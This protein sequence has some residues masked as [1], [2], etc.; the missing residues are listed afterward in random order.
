[1]ADT[2]KYLYDLVSCDTGSYPT[3]TKLATAVNPSPYDGLV[4]SI[5][6]QPQAEIYTVTPL[7]L[8]AALMSA[9]MPDLLVANL[10]SCADTDKD[11]IYRVV[12]CENLKDIRFVKLAAAQTIGD[13]LR[14]DGECTCWRVTELISTYDEIPVIASTFTDCSSCREV[15]V[16]ENCLFEERTYGY[17]VMVRVPKDEPVDRGYNECCVVGK[18]FGDRSDTDPYKNDFTSVFYQ[19]Q[20]PNDT[21]SYEI[22]GAST[23][24]NA[25]VDGT[26]G[27]LYDFDPLH[28]NPDLTYFKVEWR[29][30]LSAFGEDVYTIRKV[31]TIA[32]VAFNVDTPMSFDLQSFTIN[33][34]DGTVRIDCKQNGTLE[35]INT[36]FK[37]SGFETSLRVIGFFGNAEDKWT[38]D[39]LIYSSKNGQPMF[40]GQIT[41][42]NDPEYKYQAN[43]VPECMA[44]ELREVI[45]WGN[46]LFASDYNK[47]NHSYRYNLFPVV[48]AEASGNEYQAKSRLLNMNLTFKERSKDNRKTNC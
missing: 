18:V 31:T 36:N 37:D 17:A 40:E 25:L 22:I 23:G 15:V 3:I 20:T 7:G 33:K 10:S 4:V 27:V 1:M 2:D 43:V 29:K 14:F 21:V 44:R 16:A 32:G 19:R 30:I 28:T 6:G 42:D 24:T 47:N 48:L 39:N 9:W 46:E 5:V 11:K 41:M 13:V 35:R 12:N 45:L 34:A 8:N 26:H 38:Q